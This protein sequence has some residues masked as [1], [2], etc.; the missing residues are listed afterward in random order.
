[1]KY[2]FSLLVLTLSFSL[3]TSLSAQSSTQTQGSDLLPDIN[4]QDIEIKGDYR[5]RFP[6]LQRQ[7][8]LGFDSKPRVFQLDPYRMPF[9]E[10]NDQ[11]VASIPL[12]PLEIPTSPTK[13]YRRQVEQKNLWILGGFGNRLSPEAELGFSVTNPSNYRISGFFSHLSSGDLGFSV[14]SSFYDWSSNL[15]FTKYLSKG[16]SWTTQLSAAMLKNQVPL[17]IDSVTASEVEKFG[18]ETQLKKMT[19][20]Y[21]Y[22]TFSGKYNLYSQTVT[23]KVSGELEHQFGAKFEKFIALS[24]PMSTVGFGASVLGSSYEL[25]TTSK[26]YLIANAFVKYA[27]RFGTTHTLSSGIAP[28]YSSDSVKS[29]FFVYPNLEFNYFGF[30]S[31]LLKLGLRGEVSNGG[32]SLY[33]TASRFLAESQILQN[34]RGYTAFAYMDREL[35]AYGNLYFGV[36]F[37]YFTNFGYI[38]Y[39]RNIQTTNQLKHTIQ[40]DAAHIAKIKAGY[41]YRFPIPKVSIQGEIW[42][43]NNALS[44]GNMIPYMERFGAKASGLWYV[45]SKLNLETEL[46]FLEGREGKVTSTS[47]FV[48]NAKT[49]YSFNTNWAVYL[50]I[51]NLTGSTYQYW[52]HFNELPLFLTGGL[53]L[54]L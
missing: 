26:N 15:G 21:D 5:T 48:A 49:R 50:K 11:V 9:L 27:H 1:M 38:D 20:P 8:I 41:S 37:K 35:T 29:G 7:P 54:T 34:N 4:P 32:R 14:P 44:T 39:M 3:F 19:N 30:T 25:T 6:G 28:Y 47:F 53:T 13:N 16:F 2:L 10:T 43:Q 42:Y 52:S 36:D 51:V 22:W 23:G 12:T 45:T 33:Q 18:F 46:L 17:K 31:T 40:Y 24:Q